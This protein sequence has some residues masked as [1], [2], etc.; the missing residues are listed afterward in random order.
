M[1]LGVCIKRV[2]DTE[3][4]IRI[5]DDGKTIDLTDV[6]FIISPYDEYAI[7]EAIQLKEKAGEGEV[8]IMSVDS[9]EYTKVIRNGLAMGA[10]RAVIIDDEGID[11]FEPFA[12]AQALAAAAVQEGI[13]ILFFGK[14]GV[15]Q[16]FHQVPALVAE[17]LGWPQVSIAVKL[18]IADSK[19]VAFR[20]V[21]GGEEKIE[22]GLPAV[23]STHKGLNEPRYPSLK[24]IMQAKKKPMDKKTLSDLDLEPLS[25]SSWEVVKVELPAARLAGRILEGEPEVQVKELVDLLQNDAKVL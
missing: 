13:E 1:K 10:D 20:E 22:C 9:G 7:E 3:T 12:V 16:D 18:D 5:A 6:S 8:V 23:I 14:H 25:D 19:V 4:R 21:E 17:I 2:P 15:G 24:G 11:P